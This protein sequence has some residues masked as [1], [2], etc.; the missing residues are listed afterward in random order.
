MIQTHTKPS[1][2]DTEIAQAAIERAS[3]LLRLAL[4]VQTDG[5]RREAAKFA[6]LMD[7]SS[8][9]AFTFAVVDE[10]FRCHD[11]SEQARHWRELVHV[12]GTPAYFSFADRAPCDA[13]GQSV[14]KS[15]RWPPERRLGGAPA[16]TADSQ[17]WMPTRAATNLQTIARRLWTVNGLSRRSLGMVSKNCEV[18]S[19]RMPPLMKTMRSARAGRRARRRV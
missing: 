8:G 15:R 10:V 18:S 17:P 12:Y 2:D 3:A 5:Q 14:L 1:Q 7:D 13:L 16:W 11:P 4:K 6:G 19:L 9:K